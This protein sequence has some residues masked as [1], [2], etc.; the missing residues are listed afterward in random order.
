MSEIEP[1]LKEENEF[2]KELLK[3]NDNEKQL[4]KGVFIHFI[5][6]SKKDSKYFV[7][8]LDFYSKC[9]PHQQRVSRDLVECVYICFPDQINEIQEYIKRSHLLRCI[10]FQKKLQ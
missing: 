9:R 8:L 3:F 5:E 6:T 7:D 2:I 1:K 10:I 4:R